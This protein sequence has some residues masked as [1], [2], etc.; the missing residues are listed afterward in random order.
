MENL[1]ADASV[2]DEFRAR[3]RRPAGSALLP[4]IVWSR[5]RDDLDPYLSD[6]GAD[7]AVVLTFFHR[8]FLDEASER[9][10]APDR[11]LLHRHLAEYFAAQPL[12]V[13]TARFVPNLRKLSEV[14]FQHV[15]AGM[16]DE[17]QELL[18][19][20]AFLAARVEGTGPDSLVDDLDRALN[21]G[22][23]RD[24]AVLDE[25][26]DAVRA[27]AHVLRGDP[28]QLASQLAGRLAA[29][30]Q[31]ELRGLLEQARQ[32]DRGLWL[33]PV[34][35]SLGSATDAL[36]RVLGG[37]QAV[38]WKVAV[39]STGRYAVS[40]GNDNACAVWD[41]RAHARLHVL[42]QDEPAFAAGITSD[43]RGVVCAAG[44]TLSLWDL[45]RGVR[46]QAQQPQVGWIRAL[47]LTKDGHAIFGSDDGVVGS[48]DPENGSV[49]ILL[50][51]S[52]PIT[53]LA[54]LPDEQTVVI[55]YRAELGHDDA[56]WKPGTSP[57]GPCDGQR[58]QEGLAA[59]L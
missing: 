30:T 14:V 52:R 42:R 43:E 44:S 57:A 16:A 48:W 53:C 36:I 7:G 54:A 11:T 34:T 51:V 29:C 4:A 12:H 50:R 35:S 24:P 46:L 22:C 2:M 28:S 5:L 47:H 38:V 13:D 31:P 41:L 59:L 25:L 10:L 9:Y 1:A 40:A 39:S 18:T 15:A 45:P 23:C 6:R 37:H 49:S 3:S 56:E 32:G 58:P 55:G 27:R 17:T 20:F 19:S 26:R 21:A 8:E 33:R